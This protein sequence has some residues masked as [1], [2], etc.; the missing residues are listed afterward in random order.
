MTKLPEDIY[1]NMVKGAPQLERGLVWCH[2]CGNWQGVDA[3]ACLRSGWPECCGETMS[4]DSPEDRRAFGA[5]RGR[6]SK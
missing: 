4:V 1:A 3:A 6:E 2:R 5:G